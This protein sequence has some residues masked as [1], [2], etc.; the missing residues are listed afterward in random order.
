MKNGLVGLVMMAGLLLSGCMSQ[1]GEQEDALA[2]PEDRS[3]FQ[4]CT[5]DYNPVCGVRKDGST[6]TYSNPCGA[7]GDVEVQTYQMGECQ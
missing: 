2:C 5:M 3:V 7:C 4:M 1:G 6:K